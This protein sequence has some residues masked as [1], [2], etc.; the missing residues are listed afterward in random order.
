MEEHN[1]NALSIAEW[2]SVHPKVE[3]VL[4]PGLVSHPQHRLALTQMRGFGGTFHF[5]LEEGKRQLFVC[6]P[7]FRCLRSPNRWAA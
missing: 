1:R 6:F 3:R 2:L 4:H 7:A 5:T